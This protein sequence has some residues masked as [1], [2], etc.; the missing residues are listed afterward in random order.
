M[1]RSSIRSGAA[2]P[3]PYGATATH[4]ACRGDP[5]DQRDP[6]GAHLVEGP[7]E[8]PVVI[9]T[10]ASVDHQGRG[11]TSGARVERRIEHTDIGRDPAQGHV[12]E[13]ALAQV[14]G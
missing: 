2:A 6:G 4:H 8:R 14:A 13:A 3:S 12:L 9:E 11:E 5:S 7:S 1:P 10:G